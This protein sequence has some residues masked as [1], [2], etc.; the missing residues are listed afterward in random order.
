L[1]KNRKLQDLEIEETREQSR[2]QRIIIYSFVIGF[3]IIGFFSFLLL[4]QF[5]QRKKINRRLKLQNEE[6]TQQKEEI[7]SQRDEIE[8][9]RDEIEA[10]RDLATEQRDQIDGQKKEITSSIEYASKIQKVLLPSENVMEKVLPEHFVFY[11]PKD[12]VSGDFYWVAGKKDLAIAVAADC[13]GHGVPGAFMS[14]LGIAYL[15]EVVNKTA[16]PDAA[17]ILNQL[18]N[19]I[20]QSL[21]QTDTYGETKDGMDISLCIINQKT[22][23]LQYAGAQNPV[24]V[25]NGDRFKE[26]K[27]DKMPIGIYYTKTGTPFTNHDITLEKGAVIYIFS[28]GFADQFGGA[29]GKKFKY[30]N[31]KKLLAGMHRETMKEQRAILE[32]TFEK[33]RK[34]EAGREYEQIDDVLVMGIKI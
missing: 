34:H 31:F 15:N 11:R 17:E 25:I 19:K 20:I 8:S 21:H 16:K 24:Y 3:L 7:E 12:I 18:R 10:Q 27:G 29:D 23:H 22:R 28:D 33:W 14:M 5:R 32:K 6:I 13:T 1:N 9:Q 4:R 2:K 30:G 26:I